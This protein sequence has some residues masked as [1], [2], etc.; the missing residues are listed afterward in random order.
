MKIKH[1]ILQRF[2][3][4]AGELVSWMNKYRQSQS[5]DTFRFPNMN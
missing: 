2:L 4:S 3:S 1:I 5:N